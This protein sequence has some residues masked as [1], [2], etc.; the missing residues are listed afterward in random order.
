MKIL[1]VVSGIGYGDATREHA[2]ILALKKKYP[3]AR[4]MVQGMIILMNIFKK[5]ILLYEFEDINFLEN[6]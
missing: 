6:L 5:N 1:F 3:Q 2:N 4:I